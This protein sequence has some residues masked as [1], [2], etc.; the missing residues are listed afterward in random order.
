MD[1]KI[2]DRKNIQGNIKEV[3][4]VF[5][6]YLNV[7]VKPIGIRNFVEHLKVVINFKKP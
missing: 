7:I 5:I 4:G 6:V 1:L 3:K 2:E